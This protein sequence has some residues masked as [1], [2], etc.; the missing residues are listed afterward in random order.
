MMPSWPKT[1]VLARVSCETNDSSMTSTLAFVLDSVRLKVPYTPSGRGWCLQLQAL[2]HTRREYCLSL[3]SQPGSAEK[4]FVSLSLVA[5]AC[6]CFVRPPCTPS[7][8][9]CPH[10]STRVGGHRGRASVPEKWAVF[11]SPTQVAHPGGG[12][13]GA[14]LWRFGWHFSLLGLRGSERRTLTLAGSPR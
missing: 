14:G 2:P 6:A 10:L 9:Q 13:G 5:C 3:R 11:P 4:A 8:S 7:P 1:G 12:G